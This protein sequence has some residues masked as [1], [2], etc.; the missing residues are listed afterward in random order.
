M[1]DKKRRARVSK[2]IKPLFVIVLMNSAKMSDKANKNSLEG[3]ALNSR[4]TL[5]YVLSLEAC[6]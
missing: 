3:R 5:R 1:L 4:V 2:P 6:T